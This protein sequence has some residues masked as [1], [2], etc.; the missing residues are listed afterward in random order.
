MRLLDSTANGFAQYV[1]EKNKKIIL[2]GAGAVAKTYVP[3]IAG[4]YGLSDC[5]ICAVDNNSVKHGQ[6]IQLFDR[7]VSIRSVEY[8]EICEEDYCIWITNGDFY[9]VIEQLNDIEGCACVDCFIAAIMQLEYGKDECDVIYKDSLTPIIPK[10]IHYCWFSGRPMS[11]ELQECID[12]WSDV[13][14]DYEI[15]RWDESNYDVGKYEYSKEAYKLQKWG[16][17]PDIVRLDILYENGGFYFDTDVRIV[18]NLDNLCF[19]EA[20]CGRERQGHVNFGGG[21]GCIRH[22]KIVRS[23]LDFRK[24]VKFINKDGS[25]NT[26]ASGFYETWPLMRMGLQIEDKS[27]KLDGINIYSSK[28]F[29]PYNF[30]NGEERIDKNTFSIHYFNGSWIENGDRLRKQTRDKYHLIR[31]TMER[32]K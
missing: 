3:Y 32:I 23:L 24:N 20:F 22:N 2:F 27:Q 14:P 9:S 4:K 26:E 15:V 31:N 28:Y 12:S 7:Q 17:V 25:L 8:L 11:T 6:S 16:F 13:C 30:V 1:K 18:K 10:I 21:S 19:Q 29:S 5:I